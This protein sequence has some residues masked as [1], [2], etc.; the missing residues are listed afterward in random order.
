MS[1]IL[2]NTSTVV[3]RS[4]IINNSGATETF[5]LS[6]SVGYA[7]STESSIIPPPTPLLR[8]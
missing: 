2:I 6:S 8:I 1:E 4:V 7:T 5:W 3:L